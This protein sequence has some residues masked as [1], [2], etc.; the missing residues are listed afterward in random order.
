MFSCDRQFRENDEGTGGRK[1]SERV[2]PRPVILLPQQRPIF[3]EP[4]HSS[5]SSL[6]S[7]WGSHSL[8]GHLLLPG[9]EDSHRRWD[10]LLLWHPGV[11]SHQ[12][13]SHQGESRPVLPSD[14]LCAP[15][16]PSQRTGNPHFKSENYLGFCS[17]L[18]LHLFV[19][20]KHRVRKVKQIKTYNK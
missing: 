16:R 19:C 14:K 7:S 6:S 8:T 10:L 2:W 18:S 11:G 1:R 20:P 17:F 4:L 5:W 9:R 12:P 3:P 15:F 13:R